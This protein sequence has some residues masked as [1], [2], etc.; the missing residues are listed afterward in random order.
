MQQ[1]MFG[2]NGT[3]VLNLLEQRYFLRENPG[4]T[5]III[6]RLEIAHNTIQ[7]RAKIQSNLGTRVFFHKK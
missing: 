6:N 5:K 3:F 4:P 7:T 1:R 2:T